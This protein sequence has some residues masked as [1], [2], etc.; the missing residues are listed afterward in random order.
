V[1]Y[2]NSIQKRKTQEQHNINIQR[3]VGGR[4]RMIRKN[5]EQNWLKDKQNL[6]YLPLKRMQ[7]KSM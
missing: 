1:R 5:G 3:L 4:Q 6:T 2:F 7:W